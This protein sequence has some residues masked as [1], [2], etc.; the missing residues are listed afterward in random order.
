MCGS[1]DIGTGSVAGMNGLF[2]PGKIVD[3]PPM[4]EQLRYEPGQ[5]R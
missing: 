4:N 3:T 2:N 1:V 5:H